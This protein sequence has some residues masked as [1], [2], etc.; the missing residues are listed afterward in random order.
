MDR[1]R[2]AEEKART[3]QRVNQRDMTA[4]VVLETEDGEEY[5]EVVPII[6]DVCPTCEGKGRHVNP[7]IDEEG[8]S[9]EQFADD[10]EFREEY[11]RGTYDVPCYECHGQRVVPVI[12]TEHADPNVVKAIHEREDADYAYA[13]ERE[14]ERKMGY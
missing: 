7:S 2:Y 10:P 6:F 8:I 1:R 12:D 14:Y 9:E 4:V 3:F 11:F 5:E 13:R